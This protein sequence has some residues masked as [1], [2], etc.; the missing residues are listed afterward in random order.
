MTQRACILPY[1]SL[2]GIEGEELGFYWGLH[3][4]KTHCL[5][6]WP[7]PAF[8]R[9]PLHLPDKTPNGGTL[10]FFFL[11]ISKT[12][13]ENCFLWGE[14]EP[15]NYYPCV[16]HPDFIVPIIRSCVRG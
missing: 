16:F 15:N 12:L 2:G 5:R 11:Q 13:S 8:S 9:K 4:L 6:L 7:I 14:G 1:F 10:F 3:S